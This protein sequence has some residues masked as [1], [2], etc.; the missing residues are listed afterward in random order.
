M[1]VMRFT[2]YTLSGLVVF[3]AAATANAQ[4]VSSQVLHALG[5]RQGQGYLAM[6]DQLV[7]RMNAAFD[8]DAVA[9]RSWQAGLAAVV[10]NGRYENRELFERFDTYEKSLDH[11]GALDS[12]SSGRA[13][14]AG[15]RCALYCFT[16]RFL[17]ASRR[18]VLSPKGRLLQTAALAHVSEQRL[19]FSLPN[20][21]DRVLSP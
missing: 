14:P 11:V 20:G 19:P 5:S 16:D 9:V 10:L 3:G 8:V 1:S 18:A 21:L 15:P 13:V 4:A 17:T 6:R 7:G 12:A 2:R